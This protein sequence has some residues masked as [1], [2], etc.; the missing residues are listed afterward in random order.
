MK[1]I[2]ENTER[3]I[4]LEKTLVVEEKQKKRFEDLAF[5]KKKEIEEANRRQ[6]YDGTIN[7][8]DALLNQEEA[9]R[10][11]LME[12]MVRNATP[13]DGPTIKVLNNVQGTF[14]SMKIRF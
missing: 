3:L 1:C 8:P 6:L 11:E 12:D 4:L 14:F 2:E 7:T 13:S 10:K 5:Q 9:I